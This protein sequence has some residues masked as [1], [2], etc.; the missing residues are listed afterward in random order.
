MKD[1]R[2]DLAS[3]QGPLDLLLY[4]VQQEEVDIYE[5]PIARI[6]DRF[7]E[8]C[9][10]EVQ[11]LDVDQAGEFLVMA[12]QLL[13]LKSRALLPRD[14]PVD[15]EE[16][17]PRLDLVRQ[18]LEYRRYKGVSAELAARWDLQKD[19]APIKLSKPREP[20]R[21]DEELVELDL[22]G[23]VSTFARLLKE[24]GDDTTVHMAKER[25]PITH[26][27]GKIFDQLQQMGGRVRCRRLRG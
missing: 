25:L 23:L 4:L 22:Y 16:I 12:S 21:G 11:G 20:V 13:V 2:V 6:A 15:L 8:I 19:K 26:F 9:Q 1:L 7:L 5:V 3:F 10:G 17:D 18:L 27:V 24:T 14:D